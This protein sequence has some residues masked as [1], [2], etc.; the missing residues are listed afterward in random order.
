MEKHILTRLPTYFFF[1]TTKVIENISLSISD[2]STSL[3][4]LGISTLL[5]TPECSTSQYF[6][7][8]YIGMRKTID[9]LLVSERVTIKIQQNCV[10][11]ADGKAL[12]FKTR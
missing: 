10:F 5:S 12:L 4:S 6:R 11:T 3:S 1:N 9:H 2:I 7:D 8:Q